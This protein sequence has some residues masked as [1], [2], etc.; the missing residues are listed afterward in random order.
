MKV[1]LIYNEKQIDPNDVINVFGMPTKE[2]YSAKAVEEVARA[3]EKG[4]HNVKV[5]EDD[6]HI[7]DELREFMPKVMSGEKLG[8]VF[9]MA[10]GIQGTAEV[11]RD[12]TAEGL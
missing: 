3:L 11:R 6:I 7:I 10:Y 4:G 2:H 9:N 12:G 8:M 1:A 5:I